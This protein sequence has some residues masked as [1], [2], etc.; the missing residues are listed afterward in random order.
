MS[1]FPEA[2]LGYFWIWALCHLIGGLTGFIIFET[3][4]GASTLREKL[5][6]SL[7]ASSLLFTV[8]GT[9]VCALYDHHDRLTSLTAIGVL[10]LLETLLLVLAGDTRGSTLD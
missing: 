10:L 4:Y 3:P 2:L 6:R 9:V 5:V 1:T 7:R 8:I